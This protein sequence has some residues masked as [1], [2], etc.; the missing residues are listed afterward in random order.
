MFSLSVPVIALRSLPR[1]MMTRSLARCYI[2]PTNALILAC[3]GRHTLPFT[4]D[5][6]PPSGT[7]RS[8][9]ICAGSFFPFA[10]MPASSHKGDSPDASFGKQSSHAVT[11]VTDTSPSKPP[12][13]QR[14]KSNQ[15]STNLTKSDPTPPAI[16]TVWTFSKL[17]FP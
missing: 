3:C 17:A 1:L 6:N 11:P 7:R 13:I 5:A 9:L 12:P 4:E 8:S 2:L 16:L 14:P 10:R 15:P